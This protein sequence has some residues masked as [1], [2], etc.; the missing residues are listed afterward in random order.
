MCILCVDIVYADEENGSTSMS[1]NSF[2]KVIYIGL[3][4][5]WPALSLFDLQELMFYDSLCDH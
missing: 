3:E 4:H 1:E 5:F 2:E